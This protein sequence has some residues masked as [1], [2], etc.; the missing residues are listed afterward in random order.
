LR[1]GDPHRERPFKAPL[2]PLTPLLFCATCVYMLY[3]SLDYAGWLAIAG[4]APVA[5]GLVLYAATSR[6]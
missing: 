1:V 6:R 2:F 5:A 4:A 3:S